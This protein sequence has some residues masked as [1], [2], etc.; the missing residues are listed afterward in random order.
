M[1]DKITNDQIHVAAE[2]AIESLKAQGCHVYGNLA[3]AVY[4]SLW[5]AVNELGPRW[6]EESTPTDD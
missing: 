3:D 5:D 1:N 6:E 4:S 2:A